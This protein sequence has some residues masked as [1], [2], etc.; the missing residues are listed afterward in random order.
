[1]DR[2]RTAWIDVAKGMGI[3]MVF[4]GHSSLPKILSDFIWAF[5]MPLFFFLSGWCTNWKKLSPKE[6]LLHRIKTLMIPFFIYSTIVLTIEYVAGFSNILLWLHQGWQGYALWFIPVLFMASFIA[7]VINI[8]GNKVVIICEAV[9]ILLGASLRYTDVTLPWTMSTVPY[10]T[11]LIL[12]GWQLKSFSSY[13]EKPRIW[14]GVIGLV[15]T[16]IVSHFWRLDMAWNNILPIIPL[17]IG[18]FSGFF[19]ISTVASVISNRIKFLSK[20]LQGVGKETYI[21]LAFSQV[22]S[23][24]IIN[25]TSIDRITR[26]L[27]VI[28]LLVA[29]KYLKDFVN[30]HIGFKLLR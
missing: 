26:N 6:F 9:C 1:M 12:A 17:T 20:I 15:I 13:I 22:L 18:A 23:M 10:A 21:V 25:C 29:I 4:I 24:T 5:H 14:I 8:F 19:L 11:F 3:I 7:R 16:F 27:I 30:S 28:I 2:Q